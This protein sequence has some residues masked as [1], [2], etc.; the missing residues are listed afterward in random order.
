M[1]YA[2]DDGPPSPLRVGK[3]ADSPWTRKY[4]TWYWKQCSLQGPTHISDGEEDG[5]QQPVVLLDDSDAPEDASL[6]PFSQED[7]GDVLEE[8]LSPC[9][10]D[11][12]RGHEQMF[13]ESDDSEQPVPVMR[14]TLSTLKESETP[15][16]SL[17]LMSSEFDPPSHVDADPIED[18]GSLSESA[19]MAM[20]SRPQRFHVMQ[21]RKAKD[22]KYGL[23]RVHQKAL[24]VTVGYSGIFA[25]KPVCRCPLFWDKKMDGKPSCWVQRPWQGAWQDLPKAVRNKV[26]ELKGDLRWS[27]R[28]GPGTR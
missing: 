24:R 7:A 13:E 27:L 21:Q 3:F 9:S 6:P 19:P 28:H 14:R 23:C 1:Q 12:L 26:K 18:A 25:G 8:P 22:Y 11:I 10:R 2:T 20:S 4:K 16:A 5:T 17:R 15:L